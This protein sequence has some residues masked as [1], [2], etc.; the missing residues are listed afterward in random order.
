MLLTDLADACRDSGLTV[1]ELSGWATNV[2]GG[3]F[4][5]EGVLVHHTG[6]ASDS[7]DY[8]VWMAFTGRP[9]LPPP[10]TNL[11][12]DRHGIVYVCSAGNANHGG[13][14]RATGPMPAAPDANALYIGIEA[15]NTGSEGWAPVQ[16]KAYVALCAALCRRYGWPASHVRAHRE[17]SVTGK[18]DPGLL[19]MDKFRT[20]IAALIDSEDDTVTPEQIDKIAE[21]AAAAVLNTRIDVAKPDG[22]KR[23]L[24]VKQALVEVWQRT[25][26]SDAAS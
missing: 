25:A 5:P 8:A 3:S 13:Q 11:A 26:K 9:D 6:G 18:W 12:L 2:S 1:V 4:D 15:M 14:A 20:D 22:T 23:S 16:Y 21:Q 7:R 10:I 24:S 19:D 17:T